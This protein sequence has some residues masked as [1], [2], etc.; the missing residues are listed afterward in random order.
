MPTIARLPDLLISQIAA[1][2]VVERP[3]SV[4]KELLENSLDAG[5]KAIQ[6]HLEEGGVKLIRITDDGCGIAKDELALALTRHATSKISSLDD[7]ERVGTLGF[8]GEALASVASVARL[9]ITSRERGAAHAWKLR[10]EPGAE[11]EP[12]A[13]MAGTVVEMRDLYFNTPAR[14]KFLK[15]ES[16]EFAHCADAVKRL[17]LTR[18][19]VAISLTHNGRNLFQLAPADAPRR[20]A[21]ILGDDFLGAARRI[22]AGAGALSI[23]GFAIDPTRATDAKDGQYVFVNGR[24]VR[25]KIISHALREAYRDVLHGSRQPAVCLFVNIDPALVDVNVHPAKT[26]V[27]FRDSR[28]MHQFVFHAI[29]RTLA[30]PVQAESA[31]SLIE[32]SEAS[33][34]YSNSVVT[35]ANRPNYEYAPP[36]RHQGSLGVAEPAAAAYLAFARAVQDIG[37]SPAP[38]S[39]VAPQFQPVE[40]TGSDGPPLGYALA[41]LHGIY[42]LAQNARGLILIDMHAAHERILYEKL[43]TAFDNRQIAT[44]ALLIP[45]V[46]SADPLDIAAVEEHADALADLG[47]SIAP[48]GPNQLGVRAVPALLQ[49]GDPA[50]LAKSLIVELREHGITQLATARRNELLATMACHGA[51]R[52][53]RQLTLPEMNALLRQM[54]ET[55]RAGQCNHGRPTWTELT[56]D[57]LDKLF[58]RGQ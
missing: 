14:R 46:F 17:A 15:S 51:V 34:E 45:A 38:R 35:P 3:A 54:E 28:A 7:L 5:S 11:P 47:F 8:R 52:A 30:A 13:L 55:E 43:K 49:S 2:E 31:P 58:L 37:Q 33:S 36:L 23:G 41:Q 56:M 10:G 20:I 50:A 18:P 9:T 1:G 12:A 40:S 27:R 44:Q 21:D 25:D 53:R 29:Q 6:V 48:L 39:E 24:F 26:E 57:Q 4:L 16:T 19:D 42:I 22:E 32:R